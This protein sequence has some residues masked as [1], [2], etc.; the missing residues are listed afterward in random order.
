[1]RDG[2]KERKSE[3]QMK[4]DVLKTQHQVE[5]R[6][7]KFWIYGTGVVLILA[8]IGTVTSVMLVEK[9]NKSQL[10]AAAKKPIEGVQTSTGLSQTHTS[11]PMTSSELPPVGGAH[12]PTWVTCGVYA[13]P[14]NTS[15]AVHSLEHGAVWVTYRPDLPQKQISALT[16]MAKSNPYQLLSPYLG[17]A[18]PVV[19]TAWGKQLKLESAQDP[20][21][22]VFLQAYLQGPQTPELG[23]AC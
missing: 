5:D 4:S 17:L 16:K 10:V 11:T 21:L 13:N 8:L 1:M 20:R 7:S 3:R 22:A 15:E 9:K 14:I 19:A 12:A 6:R 18:A 23:A 2:R